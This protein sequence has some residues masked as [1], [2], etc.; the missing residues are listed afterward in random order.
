MDA[1]L[2][3]PVSRYLQLALGAE[4]AVPSTVRMRQSGM[5]RTST[6]TRRWMDFTAVH[7]AQPLACAFTWDAR[8][9][10]APLLHVRVRDVLAEGIGSGEVRLQS[11]LRVG[12][13]SGTPEMNSGSL[14]RFLAEAPWYPWALRPGP[15][16]G[17][18]HVAA[19]RAVATLSCHGSTVS[20]EFRFAASGEISGIYTPARWGS[21]E[22]GYRQLPWEG[23]FLEFDRRGGVLVPHRAEV[24]WHRDGRL[25]LVWKGAIASWDCA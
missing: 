9:R 4:T 22:G 2:P 13:D 15:M 11:L 10:L 14:H 3:A 5:L 18:K 6:R 16:L 20:L 23:R 25:G 12:H 24:G 21:F 1:S 7:T 17:W 19:D 8:V